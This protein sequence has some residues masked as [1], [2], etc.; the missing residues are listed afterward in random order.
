MITNA[1]I[2]KKIG[3][4]ESKKKKEGIY[5]FILLPSTKFNIFSIL[6]TQL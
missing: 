5:F 4:Q 3:K 6:V 2:Y 1:L